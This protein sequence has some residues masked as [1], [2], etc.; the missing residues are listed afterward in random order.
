MEQSETV[1]IDSRMRCNGRLHEMRG[2]AAIF[3]KENKV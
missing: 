3:Q 2:A 1:E